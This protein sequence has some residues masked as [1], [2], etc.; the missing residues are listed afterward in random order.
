MS[1]L[2]W[3][4]TGVAVPFGVICIVWA[5]ADRHDEPLWVVDNN[6]FP[7][8]IDHGLSYEELYELMDE[9]SRYYPAAAASLADTVVPGEV[10]ADA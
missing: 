2:A 1:D 4:I 3:W 10:R 8:G 7:A 6:D 5:L 9:F